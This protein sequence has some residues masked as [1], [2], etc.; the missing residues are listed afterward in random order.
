MVI[1][2]CPVENLGMT[3]GRLPS[4]KFWLG[5]KVL[6]T[7]HTG[8]KG[9]W[10]SILL[11]QL[12]AE[13][14]GISL[15]PATK[16]SLFGAAN[17]GELCNANHMLDVRDTSALAGAVENSKAEII[18]H[19]AAQ[20]IVR[21][22]YSDP[23]G[24]FSANVMGTA[25]VLNAARNLQA[26]K[27]IVVVTSDKVYKNLEHDTPY[28]EADRLGGHDPY[29]ASKAATEIV[30][31]SMCASFFDAS[32]PITTARAGNVIGGGDWSADRLLPDAAR[33]WASHQVLDVRNP[34]AVRPWQHVLE[35]LFAY[36]AIAETAANGREIARTYNIGPKADGT[37]TVKT[38]ISLAQNSFGRGDMKFA[39]ASSGPHEAG[40]LTLDSTR[41][42]KDLGVTPRWTVQQAVD[43]TMR[44]YRGFYAGLDARELCLADIAAYE[45]QLA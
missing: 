39:E 41:I 9:S 34:G 15:P 13:V 12:G 23:L 19:L 16:P 7:G 40:L 17:I 35:P 31:E 3:S 22:S 29:S 20:A 26:L 18:L 8:F 37:C 14:T 32:V 30:V 2:E 28:V 21:Q 33:A 38:L 5:R 36:L 25:N 6:L 43:H 10:L 4:A 44:W 42:A 27:C 11:R 1:G 45:L 24:T